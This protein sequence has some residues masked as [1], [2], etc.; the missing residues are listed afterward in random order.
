MPRSPTRPPSDID[1]AWPGPPYADTLQLG[2]IAVAALPVSMRAG[3]QETIDAH[4]TNAGQ[5]TWRWG[6]DARPEIR[7]GYR[8]SLDG[9]HVHE[10]IALR[11]PL[12]A[13]VRSGETCFVPV[14]V[15]PPSH[16]GRYELQLDV[17]HEGLGCFGSTAKVTLD[18]RERQS[19]AVVGRPVPVTRT[20]ARLSLLPEVEPV[21]VLGNDSDRPAY[22]DYQ[23]VTGLRESLLVG[24]ERSGRLSR[25]LRLS[26]RSVGLVR[27]ARRY[28]RTGTSHDV[29]LTG[30]LDLLA[31]SQA[32]IVA[33]TDWPEDAAPGREWWRLLTTMLLARTM[34]VP[35]FDLCRDRPR[36]HPHP[37]SARQIPRR[38]SQQP[39]RERT[40]SF[41]S[42][43]RSVV[44]V[45]SGDGTEENV[46][47][48]SSD[49]VVA[50]R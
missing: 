31:H 35:C 22:G 27:S 13:D 26:W 12:P 45:L 11:T 49:S 25:G 7:L 14:H 2:S 42:R 47:D 21:V 41:R 4:V 30:L 18:V 9:T 36:R 19:V 15:V 20:L 32:L 17:L 29:R 33:D 28:H 5:E 3:V 10:P 48:E 16:P 24:L 50:L 40:P 39:T 1:L 38:T 6:K 44:P 37:R 46:A 23:S 34:N 43:A 8:W